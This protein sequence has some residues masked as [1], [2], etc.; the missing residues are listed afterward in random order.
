[1]TMHRGF[2]TPSIMQ[3]R[4]IDHRGFPVPWFVTEKTKDGHWD[5]AHVRR[6]RFAEA[7][8]K[9]VCWVSGQPLGKYKSFCVGPMCVINR[10][11]GDPPVRKEIA[12]WSVRI[13]PFMS[14]PLAKRLEKDLQEIETRTMDGAGITLNPGVTAIYTTTTSRRRR[15]GTF[16]MGK[17]VDITWWCRGV[18]ATRQEVDQSIGSG[19]HL[20]YEAAALD[21]KEALQLLESFL[22]RAE[23][24]LPSKEAA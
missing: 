1:M 12:L 17:P 3:H 22:K 20:L 10:T 6:E 21:G 19:I 8:R 13:C 15:G 24:L 11:A 4:P 23:P 2:E 14:Q 18:P 9:N 5:F 16:D 7:V